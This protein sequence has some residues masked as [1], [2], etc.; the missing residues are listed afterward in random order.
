MNAGISGIIGHTMAL[1]IPS[2]SSL[3]TFVEH[4]VGVP[5]YRTRALVLLH[6][7]NSTRRWRRRK[8]GGLGIVRASSDVASPSPIWDDWKPVKGASA[9]SLSDILWPSAGAFAAMALLGKMDQILAPKGLSMTIAP[10]GAVSAVLFA[11]P[12]TPAARVF[13]FL[14]FFFTFR[15]TEF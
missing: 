4:K 10:L 8:R 2:T 9:P 7:M 1:P 13:F 14:F 3:R 5:G 15:N 12:S 6:G 11:T